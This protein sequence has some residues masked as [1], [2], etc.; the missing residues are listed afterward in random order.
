MIGNDDVVVRGRAVTEYL[1]TKD[2]TAVLKAKLDWGARQFHDLARALRS[3]AELDKDFD[4]DILFDAGG[5][6]AAQRE[7]AETERLLANHGASLK[8]LGIELKD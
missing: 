4:L 7:L 1:E 2:R 5:W 3:G 6:A 8:A